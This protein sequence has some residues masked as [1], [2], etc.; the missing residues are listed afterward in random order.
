MVPSTTIS[1]GSIPT[2]L[3]H[4]FVVTML[5]YC[6]EPAICLVMELVP[7]GNLADLLGCDSVPLSWNKTLL[8]LAMQVG[9]A[10]QYLHVHCS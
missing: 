8:T 1:V 4:P 2:G 6:F 10:L 3:D 9:S 5:G 7:G